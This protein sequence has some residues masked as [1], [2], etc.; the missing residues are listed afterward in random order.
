MLLTS[1]ND[2]LDITPTGKVIAKTGEEYR[3]LLT[4]EYKYFPKDRYLTTVR[5]DEVILT[6]K[7]T[8]TT[9]QDAYLDLWRW[10]DDDPS[11]TTTYFNWRGYYHA[12]YIAN[13]IIEHRGEIAN[14]T[15]QEVNQLVGEAYMMRAYCHFLLVNLYAEPYTHCTPASTRGVPIQLAADVNAVPR[16]SSVEAVYG[17]VLSDLDQAAGLMN[18]RQWETGL[19][20]RFNTTSVAALRARVC[21]YMGRWQDALDAANNVISVHADIEDLTVA[22]PQLPSRSRTSWL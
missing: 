11:V 7:A 18:V 6:A 16:S 9:D 21:L 20:Y 5:T 22:N 2:F 4:Y 3:S 13:Y 12:I 19:N 8:S 17:Q 1:C 14:A 15:Q 10:K